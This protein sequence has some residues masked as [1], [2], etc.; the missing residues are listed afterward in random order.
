M[1][2][3]VELK[4]ATI[5]DLSAIERV[6]NRL[7]DNEIKKNRA[8]EFFNDPRHHLVLAY[9]GD[10]AVGMA[11][12]FHY[13]HP[14]KDPELFIN[15]VGVKETYQNREIGRKLVK[16]LCEHGREIGCK[17]AWVGTEE[18]NISARKA[19]LAA[20]G[21]PEDESFMLFEFDL[22]ESKIKS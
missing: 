2:K 4:L 19:Y 15:E 17:E 3:D 18:S 6:G 1:A 8:I 21:I 7:F 13:I 20:D 5:D 22:K 12:G 14:D 9:D 11:S 16:F 10:E